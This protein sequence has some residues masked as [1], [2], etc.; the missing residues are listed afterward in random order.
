VESIPLCASVGSKD[1]ESNAR[2]LSINSMRMKNLKAVDL[3]CLDRL[4]LSEY[5]AVQP[6]P[7]EIGCPIRLGQ[8]THSRQPLSIL[9]ILRVVR[10]F[11]IEYHCLLTPS[12]CFCMQPY[13][14]DLTTL[15]VLPFAQYSTSRLKCI[16]LSYFIH[17]TLQ[18]SI[19][20]LYGF[21][22]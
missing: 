5:W 14:P 9:R 8:L 17:N 16:L 20:L 3:W 6:V 1:P 18:I 11:R 22:A 21:S 10:L 4:L 15:A 13:F 7:L 19:F 12:F 2:C